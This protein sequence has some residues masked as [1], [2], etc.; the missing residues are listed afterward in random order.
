M[1]ILPIRYFFFKMIF[2]VSPSNPP[3]KRYKLVKFCSMPKNTE[4]FDFLHIR[5]I[6]SASTANLA[7]QKKWDAHFFVSPSFLVFCCV[8]HDFDRFKMLPPRVWW[9]SLFF[10]II[11]RQNYLCGCAKMCAPSKKNKGFGSANSKV[12]FSRKVIQC[13]EN[14]R[15]RVAHDWYSGTLLPMSNVTPL[16]V[17][18]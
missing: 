2:S 15:P 10:H 6:F 8:G 5:I 7:R 9:Y 13:K 14:V 4:K 18:D 1:H 12:Q 11:V 17:N 3:R 16:G